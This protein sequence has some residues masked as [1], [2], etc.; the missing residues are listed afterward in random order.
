[1]AEESYTIANI[2]PAFFERYVNAITLGETYEEGGVEPILVT[3]PTENWK[4][5]QTSVQGDKILEIQPP[6]VKRVN[7]ELP[8]IIDMVDAN[9]KPVHIEFQDGSKIESL[10]FTPNPDSLIISSSKMINRYNT[11]T[12][13]VEEHWGDDLD[14]ISFSGS[15]YSFNVM[16]DKNMPTG[17]TAVS[18]NA[19]EAYKFLKALVNIY[20]T[21]GY[22]YQEPKGYSMSPVPKG[23]QEI[24]DYTMMNRYLLQNPYAI[25]NHPR[26]GMIRERL[27]NRIS[28]D[29]VTFLGYFE[30]FDITEDS[31]NPFRLMYSTV[32]KAEK[33][34][35]T[36]GL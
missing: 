7:D 6:Y 16:F 11:M 26:H 27:Y 3:G 33:T 10:K 9:I 13:W 29:Y 21:N 18:R 34:I 14:T 2:T 24:Y 36:V 15:S 17:L 32:F 12:R 31:S 8:M 30:S 25:A 35:W 19:S 1:M 22:L 5:C 23:E 4:I 28:F 20:R